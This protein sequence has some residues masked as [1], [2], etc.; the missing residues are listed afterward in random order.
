MHLCTEPVY[1]IFTFLHMTLHSD[2]LLHDFPS[3]T[4]QAT[5]TSKSPINDF[6]HHSI[7][8][9]EC[10]LGIVY[11]LSF[12]Y[13]LIKFTDIGDCHA[14]WCCFEVLDSSL[15]LDASGSNI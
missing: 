2:I 9:E 6:L 3:E 11:N 8:C 14:T 12:F 4:H 13:L 1:N 10:H 15:V 5:I 7:R